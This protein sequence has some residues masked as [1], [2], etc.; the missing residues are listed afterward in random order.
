MNVSATGFGQKVT[1]SGKDLPLEKV[2]NL[3][4]KQTGYAFFYDYT[5]FQDTKPVTLNL[6]DADIED[7]MRVC[8][9]G[10]DLDFSITNKTIS[11]VKKIG[12]KTIRIDE[13]GPQRT[14]KAQGVVYNE[15]GQPLSGANITVKET[16]KGTIANTRGEFE[17]LAP[18]NSIL[19]VSYIGYASEEI[20]VVDGI[21][22]QVYL[23][24]AKNELDKVVI[25]AYGTTTQRLS[26][27][28][29]A[30]VT[31]SE[32]ERQPIMNP[33]IALQGKVAGLDVVQT[34]GYASAPIKVEL[35]GRSA[36]N[37]IFTSDPLYI[38]DGVPLTVIELGDGTSSY[39]TG[40]S[41][42]LQTPYGGPAN[43][44]S[45]LFSLNP[46][47][48]ESIEVLKD[49]DA[50]AI[51]G[52]RGANGVILITTKKGKAGKE[53]FNLHVQEGISKVTKYWKMMNT[54]QYLTMRREALKN[55][56]ITPSLDNGDY[57]LLQFDTTRYTDWQKELYGGTGKTI[58]VQSSLSGGDVNNTYRVGASYNHSTNILTVTGADQRASVSINLGHHSRDQRFGMSI[59]ALYTS[60]KSDMISYSGSALLPP[61]AP[62]IYD[63]L[64]NLN[65]EGWGGLNTSA[66]NAYPF[67]FLKQPYTANTNFLNSNLVIS[68][69]PMKGL[70][71]SASGGYNSAQANNEIY[72][73]IAS[74]DPLSAPTGSNHI[75]FNNNKNW[76]IE[77]QGEYNTVIG[78]GKFNALIGGSMQRTNTNGTLLNGGGYTNDALIKSISNALSKTTYDNYGEYRY[79][80][81]FGRL[82]YN[83]ENKYIL[84]LNARRDGSSR[85]GVGN[86][87]GNFGSAGIAWIFS[88]ESLFKRNVSFLSFGKLRA[89]YGTTGSDNVGD[90]QYL[91]RWSSLGT[92]N[93]P[94]TGSI[95]IVP[96]QHA[97]P[98]YHWEVNKKL[99]VAMDLGFLKDRVNINVS[100][101]RNRC[102]DQLI[103]FPTPALS[104]FTSVTANSPA[105]VQNDGWEYTITARVLETK[106]VKW[107]VN[108]NMAINRNKLVAYPHF[109]QSPYVSTLIVG[110]SLNVLRLLHYIGVDPQTGQYAFYDRNH[111]G[112]IDIDY[113]GKTPDDR[114]TYDLAPDYFGGF[115]T[116]FSYKNLMVSL[117]FSFKK[118]IGQNGFL[119]PTIPGQIG[120]Q[121]EKMFI[122][123]WQK[124]G[125]IASYGGYTTYGNQGTYYFYSYSDGVYTDAS[126]IRLS[127]L[128]LSYSLSPAYSNKLGMRDCSL[129][130]HANN[131]FTITKYNGL[132]PEIQNFGSLPPSRT[133]VAG[134]SFNF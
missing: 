17:F 91:T 71:L 61:N 26:T 13:G 129:F 72:Y 29:I 110:K 35:R 112:Q 21:S 2:F 59:S 74:Q 27:G 34:S 101:Y 7:A 45:P 49:A 108:F 46:A 111:N 80:A 30:T 77:P 70:K 127:N 130:V 123:H 56:G 11:V 79:A 31:T 109:D 126:F 99:E 63:S 103:S 22:T 73:L 25:Q 33:L 4:K 62:S 64:G 40:S 92:S 14:V 69:Q 115:G 6:K 8:L 82:I 90:Y 119:L 125:D 94:Y 95:P 78:K 18:E 86:Q 39:Q 19:I 54:R 44:Q 1:I 121:S 3:I 105:L 124:P 20:K 128:A 57:D 122:N 10:Q 88:E 60:T 96:R 133:I 15:G 47:D 32:I 28:N 114:Y 9:W 36:I 118:Q 81:I 43:G 83:W 87:F 134:I 37:G 58:D 24:A 131:L 100:Y 89:S 113:S 65:Y 93:V 106:N 132:D 42:F 76:I 117:F 107:S 104:G 85:F 97:N 16:K 68:Y 102:G 5:I 55:D 75:G 41:G 53:H 116:N 84:S 12:K 120:N 67:G 38:I 23:K 98:Y 50:T 66:R 51:Y 48:I 52:S